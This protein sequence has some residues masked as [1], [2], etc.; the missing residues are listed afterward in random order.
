LLQNAFE[1]G[2]IVSGHG[3]QQQVVE[4]AANASADLLQRGAVDR[5]A[6]CFVPSRTAIERKF[7]PVAL[8]AILFICSVPLNIGVV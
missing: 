5:E 3:S 2:I 4:N 1:P 7:A 6:Y 8:P